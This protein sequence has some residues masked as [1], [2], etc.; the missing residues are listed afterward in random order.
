MWGI[1]FEQ[2]TSNDCSLYTE[3]FFRL[4]FF[5]LI[6]LQTVFPVLNYLRQ[7]S[8]FQRKTLLFLFWFF[9][10]YFSLLFFFFSDS[11]SVSLLK[12]VLSDLNETFSDCCTLAS[13][14]NV[15]VLITTSLQFWCYVI[16]LIKKRSFCPELFF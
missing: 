1:S 2:R 8:I 10:L 6:H 5:N 12:I 3:V 14:K 11:F 15:K 4:C 9:P 7:Y 16:F 13:L